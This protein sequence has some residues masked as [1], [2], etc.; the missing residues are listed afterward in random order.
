[1]NVPVQVHSTP[2]DKLPVDLQEKLSRILEHY[3][4]DLERGERRDRVQLL[5]DN[6]ELA[7]ALA[8][9]LDSFDFLHRAASQL[10]PEQTADPT[11]QE[12]PQ[13]ELGDF[14]IEREI[15]RGGMGIVYE[16]QQISLGRRVALKVLPFAAVLDRKLI[17]RFNN[18]AQA[19]SEYRPCL[20]RRPRTRRALLQHAAH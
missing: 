3:V 15:G 2:L 1:M 20:F 8:W 12:I 13:Q 14:M 4:D 19:A 7:E 11:H 10:G 9:Y 16:A 17:A 18:E 6:P 5:A